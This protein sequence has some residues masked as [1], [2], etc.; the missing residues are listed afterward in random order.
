MAYCQYCRAKIDEDEVFCPV[1]ARSL[2]GNDT[3]WQEFKLHETIARVQRR[4]DVYTALA[5]VLITLGVIGGSILGVLSDPVGLFGI[6]LVCWGIGFAT[7]ARRNDL[8]VESLRRWL[9]Q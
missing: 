8:R 1:C 6:P 4:A 2:V 9:A 7:A 3:R 5:A